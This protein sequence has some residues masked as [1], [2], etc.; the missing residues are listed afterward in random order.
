VSISRCDRSVAIQASARRGNVISDDMDALDVWRG[1]GT[2]SLSDCSGMIGTKRVL[3]LPLSF[4]E[5]TQSPS[6]QS[7]IY[8]ALI[9]F[10]YPIALSRD[11]FLARTS[12]N[13][14]ASGDLARMRGRDGDSGDDDRVKML[15]LGDLGD[16]VDGV[17]GNDEYLF[18]LVNTPLRVDDGGSS[19]GG[20]SLMLGLEPFDS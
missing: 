16:L 13:C 15:I 5:T 20:I 3:E 1:S 2:S 19:S 7:Y 17:R 10:A 9:L 4:M 11:V 14:M 6:P 18:R 8:S 12:L